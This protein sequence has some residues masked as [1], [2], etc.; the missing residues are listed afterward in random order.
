MPPSPGT[1]VMRQHRL[2]ALVQV[3]ENGTIRAAA[4]GPASR[5]KRPDQGAARTGGGCRDGT[6]RAQPQGC[7][8]FTAAGRVLLTNARLA[9]A[10][11]ERARDEIRALQGGAGAAWPLSPRSWRAGCVRPAS[12]RR[13]HRPAARRAALVERRISCRP[14]SAADRGPAGPQR[15]PSPVRTTL[16]P[17]LAFEPLFEVSAASRPA[18]AGP[19]A[20][21]G[22]RTGRRWSMP[23]GP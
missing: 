1:L 17:E 7:R 6:A 20:R 19:S 10:S 15:S 8:K 9:L 12:G 23:N 16:P 4:R 13:L 22:R 21:R 11:L 18:A 3:A 2:R 5:P 14:D